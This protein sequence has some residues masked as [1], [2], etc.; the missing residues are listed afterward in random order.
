[1]SDNNENVL[2]VLRLLL[3][4]FIVLILVIALNLVL[5]IARANAGAINIR[6][7]YPQSNGGQ[8]PL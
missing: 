5:I 1:M 2:A 6:A 3:A 4:A 7:G 8:T